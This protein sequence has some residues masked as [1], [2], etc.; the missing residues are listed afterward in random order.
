MRQ[1]ERPSSL[2]MNL[3]AILREHRAP[4]RFFPEFCWSIFDHLQQ[5]AIVLVLKIQEDEIAAA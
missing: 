1:A 2:K 5:M 3:T 4:S